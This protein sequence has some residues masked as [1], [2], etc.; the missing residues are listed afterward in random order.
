MLVTIN[1]PGELM[2]WGRPF[3]RA[4][5]RLEPSTRMTIAFVHCP[6]AT[7]REAEEAARLFPQATVVEKKKYQRFLMGR[8]IE[9]MER[10]PGALQYLGGD[11]YHA[12]TIAKR[13]GL[14]PMTYKFSK[15]SYAHTFARFFAID[16]PNAAQLRATGAPADKVRVVGNLV[17]DAVLE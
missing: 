9:G 14:A 11:L 1:G 17:A 2:G 6:Y 8:R 15:R 10:G 4:V 7:G 3:I 12:N 13:L 16:E 5:Y